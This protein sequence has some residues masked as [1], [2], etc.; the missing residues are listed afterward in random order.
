MTRTRIKICGIMNPDD[1]LLATRGGADAIGVVFYEGSRRAVTLEQA[2][3]IRAAT[4][5]MTTLVALF[6]DPDSSLVESVLDAIAPEC[7]QFHGDESPEFCTSFGRPH[8]KALRVRPGLD[9]RE[10]AL[11]Y[12]AAKAILLDAWHPTE[13]GGTGQR[14]DWD[15]ARSLASELPDR[16]V[17]AGGLDSQNVADAIRLVDPW[18][19]DVSSGVE[20]TPGRKCP[21]KLT[22]FFRE[23]HRVN[24]ADNE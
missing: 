6:V 9:V 8:M 15:V 19:V 21:D 12:G 16:V 10:R 11:H 7:L 3:K 1:A 14:F 5:A 22:N 20:Q 13:A 23:V 17:L 24:A 2:R 18:A 4:P